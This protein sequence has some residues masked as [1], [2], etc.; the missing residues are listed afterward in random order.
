MTNTFDINNFED[1]KVWDLICE[2]NTKGVFQLESNLG[3]HWAK[4]TKPRSIKDLAALVSLIRPGTL[5]AKDANGKSMTQVY[6]D[7]KARKADS[8]VE[9]LHASLEPIL[10]ETYGVLVYQE[11]SML[12]AQRLAGF[13]LK[14]A[15]GLRKAIGKKKADLMAEVK[16]SFLEGAEKEA[17]VTKEI[18]EE[19]FSW[20]EKSS[21]YA[22]NKSHA[23]S[24]AINAYWS[25]Y[26][27]TYR[28][29]KFY[30]KYLNRAERK[31]K[32]DIEKRQL[33][34][35]A[36]KG[37]VEVI[38]PRL[39]HLHINFT[40]DESK[41]VIYYGLTHIKNVGSK[42]CDKIS[43]FIKNNENVSQ[44]T[45][46]DCLFD[47]V[48]GLNINKRATIALISVGAFNG[49]NN[50]TS[51]QTM[52]YEYNSW[53]QLT[54]R[55]QQAIVNNFKSD[56]P[57]VYAKNLADAICHLAEGRSS[58]KV[59][60]KRMSVV[61]DIKLSLDNPFY[62]INDQAVVIATDEEK[63]LSCALTCS[64]VDGLDLQVSTMPCTAVANQTVSGKICLAVE[65]S[66][67]KVIKT[68]RGN[69]PGQ[70]MAFL[71]VED[72]SGSLED[73]TVFPDCYSEFRNLLIENN[74]VILFGTIS[75]KDK[76]SLIVERIKQI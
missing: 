13:N 46:M 21:R 31:P 38:P 52:L 47:M 69:N 56:D 20:I 10:K 53:K 51:R 39:Q 11:Q 19:I 33:I 70:E 66:E 40:R 41:G 74:T 14:E 5:L 62:D 37:G 63:F 1:D 44:F 28:L 4:E 27:K 36:K 75:K 30:E 55:E 50:L 64:K 15:D 29:I 6:A 42:E 43:E 8:P 45:W 2:G 59:N 48:F 49:K 18:A 9:Y 3:K 76:K 61:K 73:V 35:D 68:K 34:M 17:I 57:F 25:A 7:R 12:I 65:L 60:A 67:I 23:V 26:C 58:I 22:F 16:K 32:P 72:S 54:P 24:Y 71:T